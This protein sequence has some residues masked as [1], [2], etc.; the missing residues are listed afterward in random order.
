MNATTD[1]QRGSRIT[2]LERQ[3]DTV[4]RHHGLCTSITMHESLTGSRGEPAIEAVTASNGV[5]YSN[6]FNEHGQLLR[7]GDIIHA[8]HPDWTEGR[9][10]VAYE[11]DE[12]EDTLVPIDLTDLAA[13]AAHEVNR[14]FAAMF[15]DYTHLSWDQSPENIQNSIRF[16]LGVIAGDPG[17]TPRQQ[18]DAWMEYKLR[19]GWTYGEVRDLEAKTHPCLMP[20]EHLPSFHKTKD[21]LF[22]TVVRALLGLPV[23]SSS[24][25]PRIPVLP[26]NTFALSMKDA[27]MLSDSIRRHDSSLEA[28]PDA[29]PRSACTLID[30]LAGERDK[31]AAVI[32]AASDGIDTLID[33]GNRDRAGELLSSTA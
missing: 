33:D 8:S 4:V 13:R 1:I 15:G 31:L 21:W 25:V 32:D 27:L 14:I 10:A 28:C 20:Y 30:T 2:I 5:G 12:P 26:H 16:G 23:L 11:I 9:S 22:S 6:R 7:A 17:I 29:L 18:H 19:D 3:R 24:D